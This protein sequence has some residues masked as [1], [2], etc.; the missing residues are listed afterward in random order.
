MAVRLE[1]AFGA[2]RQKLIGLQA[3]FERHDRRKEEKVVAVHPYVP[4]FLTIRARQIHDW[5]ESNLRARHLLPVLLRRLVHSTGLELRQVDFPGYD[6]AER[7][8]W[9]GLIEAGAATPWIPEGKSSW[10]FGTNREPGR[11]AESDYGARLASVPP[12]ERAQCTFVFVTPRNWSGKTEWARRKNAA[13]D[14]K[15]VRAL[16]ASDL[17]QCLEES[18]AAQI[19]LAEA[20]GM[21]VSGFETLDLCWKH[22]AEASDPNITPQIFDPSIIAYRATFKAWL[23]KPSQ[24]P[25]VVAADSK[26]EALAFLARLFE[27]SAIPTQ[28]KDLAAVFESAQTLRTLTASSSPFIPIVCAEETERELVTVYRRLHCIVVRPRNAIDSEPDIA[29]DLLGHDAFERALAA[30]GIDSD[31]AR[32]LARES[33]CS[34][35]ILRRRLSKID[36]IRTP[37]W[38]RDVEIAK[39][40]IPMTFVGAWHAKSKADCEVVS[41]LADKRY[42]EI[43]D[44]VVRLLR[45]DDCP[46][47][48]IGQYRGVASKIDALFAINKVV[49]ERDLTSFFWLAEYVLSETDPALD[50]PED[51]RWAAGLYGKVRNHSAALRKGICETLVILAVHGKNLFRDRIGIDVEA[52]VSSLIRELLTPLSLEKLLSHDKDLPGFAEAAPGEFLKLLEADLQEPQPVLLGLLKPANSGVFGGGCPRT[53]LLWALECLAW[54]KPRTGYPNTCETVADRDR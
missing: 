43:E 46:V 24:H 21:P 52:R 25:F 26:D 41:V 14:W 53:G 42:K 35:T 11:K 4:A 5:A 48:S 37:R 2:D 38:A 39:S 27:D 6:N 40:L 22:W 51:Q 34:P 30:M 18:V 54:K 16:D 45:F 32:R 9:D 31:D 19:W 50:L 17:E 33:G 1:K 44:N 15:A 23:E 3:A 47:W 36:A 8:G 20:L 7:R 49:T 29:L 28:S 12:A 13:G 10:E